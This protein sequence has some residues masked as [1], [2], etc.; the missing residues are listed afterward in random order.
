MSDKNEGT[1]SVI[2]PHR[3]HEILKRRYTFLEGQRHGK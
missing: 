2:L 1:G 3:A